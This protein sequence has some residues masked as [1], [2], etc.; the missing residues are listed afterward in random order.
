M[1]SDVT[2]RATASPKEARG[3]PAPH[4]AAC[5]ALRVHQRWH[6]CRALRSERRTASSERRI[7]R[8]L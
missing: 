2:L 5:A 6:A 8:T 4:C 1:S 3:P 7:A